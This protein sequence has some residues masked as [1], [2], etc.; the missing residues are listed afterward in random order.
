[1]SPMDE[2][3]AQRDALLCECRDPR[4]YGRAD[5]MRVR[6]WNTGPVG[7]A[8]VAKVGGANDWAAYIG[9]LPNNATERQVVEQTIR[10]G[11]K[12]NVEEAVGLFPGLAEWAGL[13]R[14]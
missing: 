1:M 2:Q 6:Y 5:I 12:L 10:F 7:V 8:V 13:Y 11:C 3:I 9:G 4:V 14:A